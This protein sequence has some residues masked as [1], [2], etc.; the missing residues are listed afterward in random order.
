MKHRVSIQKRDRLAQTLPEVTQILRGSLLKR[1]IFHKRGCLK[2]ARGEGH[3]AWVLTVSY[4]QGRTR[5]WSIRAEQREQV[6][7]WLENYQELKKKLELVS[8]MVLSQQE[9]NKEGSP[10]GKWRETVGDLAI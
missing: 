6:A 10:I 2:C 9:Q 1:R 3:R 5:Q 4:P 7:R 8:Q